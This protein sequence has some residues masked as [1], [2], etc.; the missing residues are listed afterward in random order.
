MKRNLANAT[1]AESLAGMPMYRI[2]YSFVLL[3]GLKPLFLE[4]STLRTT[5]VLRHVHNYSSQARMHRSA[6]FVHCCTDPWT[7]GT[8]ALWIKSPSARVLNHA[9]IPLVQAREERGRSRVCSYCILDFS[10]LN[11]QT[12]D[13]CISSFCFHSLFSIDYYFNVSFL[14]RS[15]SVYQ[16]EVPDSDRP[17]N[18]RPGPSPFVTAICHRRDG[19]R[20]R[21]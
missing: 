7:A 2:G 12:F 6:V 18:I 21:A 13:I 19:L 1:K 15:I 16:I 4:K 3:S 5:D 17:R 10:N 9:Q 14:I 20:F 8:E 11:S